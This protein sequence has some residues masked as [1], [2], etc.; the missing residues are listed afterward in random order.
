M[1]KSPSK[2]SFNLGALLKR[3]FMPSEEEAQRLA[4]AYVERYQYYIR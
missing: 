1:T 2:A 4:E 3:L